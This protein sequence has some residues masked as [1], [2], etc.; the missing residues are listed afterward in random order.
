MLV[1]SFNCNIFYKWLWF[2]LQW[3]W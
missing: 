2:L 1:I 3:N